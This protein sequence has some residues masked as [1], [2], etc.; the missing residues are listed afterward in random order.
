MSRRMNPMLCASVLALG[1]AVPSVVSAAC[2]SPPGDVTG[3]GATTVTDVQCNIL[4]NLWALSPSGSEFPV[5]VS[6]GLGWAAADQ[7]CDSRIDVVDSL[8]VARWALGLALDPTIDTNANN[9]VDACEADLD[10][11]G[12]ADAVDCAPADPSV[13][14]GA[15]EVCNGLDD[16]CD[17]LADPSGAQVALDATCDDHDVCTGTETCGASP[18]PIQ[19]VLI[20]EVM[21]H[22]SAV[23]DAAGE[24]IELTNTT[25]SPINVG[26]WTLE[27]GQGNKHTVGGKSPLLIPAH[28]RI[29]VAATADP[30]ANGGFLAQDAWGS[31]LSLDDAAGSVTLRDPKGTIVSKMSYGKNG[32]A[33]VAGHSLALV[34]L[35]LPPEQASSWAV[36]SAP[37]GAGDSGTPG[38]PNTDVAVAPCVAG[39]PL[40]CD[41]GNV[42][43]DDACD[44][45]DGCIHLWN[46]AACD[47]GNACTTADTCAGGTCQP[48]SALDCDDGNVCT[49]D[50]CDVASGCYHT[51][52]TNPC[53]DGNACTTADTCS[54]GSCIGG[55][56][57]NCD[58][59]NPCT[60]DACKPNV[61]C[62]HSNNSAPCNDG[63]ACTTADT[64]S[65]GACVGGP[66]PNCDDGNPC[67]DDACK[68]NVGCTHSNNSAPCNDG[69]ACTTT[70][71]CSG[72]ACVGGPPPK[73]NDGN[74]CTD[75]ACNPK[76]GCTHSNNSASCNDGNACTTGDTCSGGSCIGGPPLN[77]NDGN[78][79]TND[80]CK[81]NFGCAHS[82][83]SASCNDGNPCTTGDYCSGGVCHA[84]SPRNCDDGNPCTNDWCSGGVC[85]HSNVANGTPCGGP[86]VCISGQCVYPGGGCVAAGTPV[87]TDHGPV[88]VEELRPGDRVVSSVQGTDFTLW[89]PVQRVVQRTVPFLMGVRLYDGTTLT[90]SP[91]HAFFVSGDGWVAARALRPGDLL[92]GPHGEPVP[93]DDVWVVDSPGADVGRGFQVFSP[94]VDDTKTYFAGDVPVLSYSC[95]YPLHVADRAGRALAGSA[96]PASRAATS[97]PSAPPLLVYR[98]QLGTLV[99]V[100]D[101]AD[102]HT[103]VADVPC[104]Q[105]RAWAVRAGTWRGLVFAVDVRAHRLV[106]FDPAWAAAVAGTGTCPAGARD[107]MWGQAPLVRDDTAYAAR[108]AD[109][110]LIVTYFDPPA[111][112]VYALQRPGGDSAPTIERVAAWQ[113][114]EA[115]RGLGEPAVVDHQLWVP[116]A[117]WLGDR[118]DG[119][120]HYGDAG[121]LAFAWP[122]GATSGA[123]R[124]R[125]WPAQGTNAVAVFAPRAHPDALW[126]LL[127]GDLRTTT[128]AVDALGRSFALSAQFPVGASIAHALELDDETVLLWAFSGDHLYLARPGVAPRD[129]SAFVLTRAGDLA[130]VPLPD[131]VGDRVQSD[132]QDVLRYPADSNL[133]VLIDS[134][135]ERLVV[136]R[137]TPTGAFHTV[138]Q[139]GLAVPAV[140]TSPS[141]AVWAAPETP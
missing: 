123:W 98:G 20:T 30:A 90:V 89:R 28:G 42:C 85:K 4:A 99:A 8:L 57:P 38:G 116:V 27:D 41:D 59:G 50:G 11:D 106:W 133:L 101:P 45:K 131:R 64:C 117:G 140:P 87:L 62:T 39:T 136:V 47:D 125:R 112:D 9:C 56:P 52:N 75:D 40:S 33:P 79:C 119:L 16:D 72:G 26:G 137:R 124:P 13:H 14:H 109:G 48:G 36:A 88:P 102:P 15:G 126:L 104:V 130:Q 22:P 97:L 77:C 135:R 71:T 34:S 73:C 134:K 55:P 93:V 6:G 12:D 118:G 46:N 100:D 19:G 51:A 138:G 53:D 21:A 17:G 108:I 111:V 29:V 32:L 128:G 54:N 63:N 58:D 91:G 60:D 76:T 105:T 70:D 103:R 95:A 82:N 115:D 78:P 81:P 65:G 44:P 139:T 84:G 66:P 96:L 141:W 61:G 2:L 114:G 107:H 7:N 80:W 74:P 69:N 92:A 18:A 129:V 37:Y 68:P 67:T 24:W 3:N 127:A 49:S 110:Y 31:D 43:T 1:F 25:A 113:G 120:A 10:G 94:V 122:P 5:C 35:A 121:A 86:L 83:N 132:V 23:A